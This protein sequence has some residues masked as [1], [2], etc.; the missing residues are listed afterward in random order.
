MPRTAR[1][2][3]FCSGRT[4]MQKPGWKWSALLRYLTTSSFCRGVVLCCSLLCQVQ[5]SGS[6][7]EQRRAGSVRLS[8]LTC[9]T[10]GREQSI[11]IMQLGLSDPDLVTR[12]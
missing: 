5:H 6:G 4:A 10:Y 1:T 3:C 12:G 7:M 2:T 8:H 9:W 11:A